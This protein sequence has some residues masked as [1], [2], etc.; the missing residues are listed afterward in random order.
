LATVNAAAGHHEGG[1]GGDIEGLG[2]VAAR[3]AGVHHRRPQAWMRR[4]IAAHGAG[5]AGQLLESF[6]F[7]G[8]GRHHGAD[9]GLSGLAGEH[10]V[11]HSAIWFRS[12][13]VA[14]DDPGQM[15][16]KHFSSFVSPSDSIISLW[17]F[18]LQLGF[19]HLHKIPQQTL[20]D[21]GHDRF[22]MELNAFGG[23]CVWRRP[24]ISPSSAFGGD[25]QAIGQR[26]RAARPGSDS[27]WPGRVC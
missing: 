8:Q 7:G 24:M 22:G 19:N 12:G 27:A 2:A 16:S 10:D 13:S 5:R 11:H 6:A 20:P 9:L 17:R 1:G 14:L 3:A 21:R 15:I 23:W 4:R 18:S 26:C 25:L